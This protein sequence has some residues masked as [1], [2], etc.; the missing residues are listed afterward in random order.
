MCNGPDQS[1][2]IILLH[3]DLIL[4]P[5]RSAACAALPGAQC[6]QLLLCHTKHSAQTNNSATTR[7]LPESSYSIQPSIIYQ[8]CS[9]QEM[10][11]WLAWQ[12]RDIN[13]IASP[14][15]ETQI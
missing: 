15:V 4:A 8:N 13:I 3:E 1:N 7:T 9:A 10:G 6:R 14:D 12:H 5:P 2:S 11:A